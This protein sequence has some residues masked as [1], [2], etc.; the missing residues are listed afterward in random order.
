MSTRNQIHTRTE[1]LA[2][3]AQAP[4]AED[5]SAL[6]DGADVHAEFYRCEALRLIALAASS[7]SEDAKRQFLGLAQQYEMLAE[8]ALRRSLRGV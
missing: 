2:W 3:R 8:H 1:R 6:L 7:A 4:S 5:E